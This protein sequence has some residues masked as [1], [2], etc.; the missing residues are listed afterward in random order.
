MGSHTWPGRLV[1]LRVR[2]GPQYVKGR[3][4]FLAPFDLGIVESQM[5]DFA[6]RLRDQDLESD[7][8]IETTTADGG[9][10]S[11]EEEAAADASIQEGMNE[12]YMWRLARQKVWSP[13]E[14]KY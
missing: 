13:N 2:T 11:G 3:A 14:Y 12:E 7:H 6:A 5:K 4:A 10:D 9:I 1:P 8:D